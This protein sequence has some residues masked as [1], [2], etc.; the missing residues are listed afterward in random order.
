MKKLLLLCFIAI[1]PLTARAADAVIDGV[2]YNL[3]KDAN[4][5]EVTYRDN[6]ES[7]SYREDVVIPDKITVDGTIYAVTSIGYRAFAWGGPMTSITIPNSVTSI[8]EEAFYDCYGLTSVTIP[9]SVTSIGQGAFYDC[10][11]LTNVVMSNSVTTIAENAFRACSSLTSIN[12]PNSVTTIEAYAFA[13]C[14]SLTSITIPNSVTK[15]GTA[16][17]GATGLTS[18]TIPESVKTI[19]NMA[20]YMC[21]DLISV[22]IPNSVKT[23]GEKAFMEC[24]SLPS[25]TIPNS[26][27]R[28]EE[29]AFESCISLTTVDIPDKVFYLGDRAFCQC[30]S[31][32]SVTIGDKVGTIRENAFMGCTSLTSVTMGSGVTKIGSLAFRNCSSLPSVTI[33]NSVTSI[34]NDAFWECAN[35]KSVTMGNS[36]KSIG[37]SA[38]EDCNS[39]N[40]VYISDLVA[41]CNISFEPLGNPLSAA[42]HLY[43]NGEEIKDLVIPDEVSSI[44]KLAFIGCSGLTSVTIPNSVT[45]IAGFAFSACSGLTSVTIPTSVTSIEG[46]AF[47]S[48]TGLTSVTIEATEVPTSNSYIFFEVNLDQVTLC[49][50]KGCVDIYA[51][52][53]PWSKFGK[54]VEASSV[55]EPSPSINLTAQVDNGVV[56]LLFNS[57]PNDTDYR[58]TRTDANGAK[59]YFPDKESHYPDM[60]EYVDTPPA[61]TITY[62]VAMGYLDADGK[63]KVV[64][65]EVTVT[66]AEPIVP[67]AVVLD[68]GTIMGRIACDRNPPASGLKV[69]FSDNGSTINVRGTVFYRLSVPVG[70]ELTMTVSGDDAHDYETVTV[71]VAPD[72]NK[73]AINGTLKKDYEPNQQAHDLKIRTDL[74]FYV[75]DGKHHVKCTLL[76]PDTE[77][78]WEGSVIAELVQI[79]NRSIQQI[80]SGEKPVYRGEVSGIEIWERKP[81]EIDIVIDDMELPMETEFLFYLT[82]KGRWE[83]SKEPVKEKSIITTTG[84]DMAGYEVKIGSTFSSDLSKWNNRA[85]EQFACLMLS[86]CSLTP[87]MDGMVGDLQ[88]YKQEVLSIA[89]GYD[90]ANT[91]FE[92][93][94]GKTPLEAINDPNLFNITSA[95]EKINKRLKSTFTET[96]VGKYYKNIVGSVADMADAEEMMKG[97]K[98]LYTM[99]SE[100]SWTP[101]NCFTT[102]MACASILYRLASMGNA[103]P[104]TEMLFTYQVVGESFINAARHLGEIANGRHILKRLKANGPYTG[105][106]EGQVNTAVDFKLVVTK[107]G[108][109]KPID[110]TDKDAFRQIKDIRI[111]ADSWQ[112]TTPAEFT[113]TLVP[114]K[115]C[116]VLKSDG[117]G[118]TGGTN[119]ID[120]ENGIKVLYMEIDW[121]NERRTIIPIGESTNGVAINQNN[122]PIVTDEFEKYKPL[123]YTVTLTTT[124]G[125]DNM[126]D[127]LYLGSNKERK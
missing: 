18:V 21:S 57:V 27:T 11:E 115:D 120:S 48:C 63:R 4:T 59:N 43:L 107:E 34:E 83:N 5:A 25:I 118:I 56:R 22:T 33:P 69:T 35:L 116:I 80:C 41:W 42:H 49:V 71:R 40:S 52:V 126:A 46:H 1:L 47:R 60:V 95:I 3:N 102:S 54:I 26:V 39:L 16:A 105:D 93:V 101:E 62:E 82:S 89:G 77:H 100:E 7:D 53:V 64:K 96:L 67:E 29:S 32:V 2:Y 13:S 55:I 110:F 123:D 127:E 12:L 8:G 92:W 97:M 111:K 90:A 44:G 17:F 50:P 28:I 88:P 38:F 70:T 86:L 87:G 61:G 94:E 30:T 72:I 85:R 113:F 91:V 10:S 19:G 75:Q 106:K 84:W 74:Q 109:K 103:V 121:L 51:A 99:V 114:Q 9:N 31:L 36:V 68:Y 124:T 98:S 81:I 15:I 73:V 125:T 76:N 23:I 37:Y 108:K 6:E 112:S 24:S 45:S 79:S 20:F 122:T 119:L 14:S 104:L 78:T 117:K 65:D 66:V 58:I